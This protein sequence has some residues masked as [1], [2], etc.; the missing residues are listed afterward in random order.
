LGWGF[1]PGMTPTEASAEYPMT[2]F[3]P[4]LVEAFSGPPPETQ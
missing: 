1:T 3:R 4:F 2:A